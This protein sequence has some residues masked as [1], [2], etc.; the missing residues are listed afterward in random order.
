M[1]LSEYE[2]SRV[3]GFT[4]IEMLVIIGILGIIAATLLPS[5]TH[6]KKAAKRAKALTTV[7]DAKVA[8]NLYLQQKRAWSATML[9][10]REIDYNVAKELS[11]EDL[12]DLVVPDDPSTS[13][14]LD[15]F[16]LL[17]DWGRDQLRRNPDV[18]SET[19]TG[20]DGVDISDHR[21]QFRLDENYDGYVDGSEGS[22]LG[23]K[24]RGNVILWSRGPDGKDDFEN[25]GRRY[26]Y[27]DLISWD[28]SKVQA[29]N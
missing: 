3:S 18:T 27:D 10:A 19:H 6:L 15:R 29:E 28:H 22:P 13:T 7:T 26:P 16:G 24:I 21:I 9:E 11:D 25:S 17:D 2:K 20:T 4:L 14:S 5:V 1:K 12:L 8:M 23:L